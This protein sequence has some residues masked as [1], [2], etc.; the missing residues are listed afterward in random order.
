MFTFGYA[1]QNQIANHTDGDSI[2]KIRRGQFLLSP[3]RRAENRVMVMIGRFQS[4][5][6]ARRNWWISRLHSTQGNL[7]ITARVNSTLMQDV[8]VANNFLIIT[9]YAFS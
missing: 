8:R 7:I 5:K 2:L 1:G 6:I 9:E 3:E 4:A